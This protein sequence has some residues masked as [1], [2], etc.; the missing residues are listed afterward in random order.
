MLR[1]DKGLLRRIHPPSVELH[2]ERDI[3]PPQVHRVHP[4]KSQADM[5]VA[6]ALESSLRSPALSGEDAG[7]CSPV[8]VRFPD[9][10]LSVDLTM[11]PGPAFWPAG[12]DAAGVSSPVPG[13]CK[14]Q[15]MEPED[16]AEKEPDVR[17]SFANER[18]FLAWNRTALALIAT[19]IAATQLLPSFHF[20]G[21]RRILGL[22]LVALGAL[23]AATSLWHWRSNEKA[24]RRGD[25]LPRSPMPYVLAV[26]ILAV[27]VVGAIL[28][29]YGAR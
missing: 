6:S 22:P 18:T 7:G 27:A 25:P 29:G 4:K 12:H 8:L 28:A 17:F 13:S 21:G 24:M 15:A 11:A 10:K 23:V 19:G 20:A 5:V 26:G 2:Q 14:A 1:S 16:A 9:R 3:E